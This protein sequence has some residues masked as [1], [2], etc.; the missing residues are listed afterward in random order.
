MRQPQSASEKQSSV[1]SAAPTA[2]GS[3]LWQAIRGI[4]TE[5]GG[6]AFQQFGTGM[7]GRVKDPNI[8]KGLTKMWENP[9]LRDR[10][11]YALGG[12]ATGGLGEGIREYRRPGSSLTSTL[13]SAL[14][15]GV[16]GGGI[17]AAAGPTIK[18]YM[19]RFRAGADALAQPIAK[20]SCE[21][22]GA[23]SALIPA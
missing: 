6:K 5:A 4:G 18:P 15:G 22:L 13:S 12:A 7:I 2:I 14:G 19:A 17:G 10:T 21:R 3:H 23:I 1:K 9:V 11:A 20:T 8:Q 16:I